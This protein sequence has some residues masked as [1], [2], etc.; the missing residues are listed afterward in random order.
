MKLRIMGTT[1]ICKLLTEEIYKSGMSMN[2]ISKNSG[3][4]VK[5]ICN[6]VNGICIPSIENAQCVLAVLG[7]ELVIREKEYNTK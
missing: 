4:D 1:D 7:K 2:K 6:W 5:T 3:V